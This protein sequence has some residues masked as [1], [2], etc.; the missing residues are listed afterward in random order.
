MTLNLKHSTTGVLKTSPTGFSW[1]TLFFGAFV[2]L[3]RGD[4]KWFVI[5]I[6]TSFFTCGLAWLVIPFIYNKR[7]IKD[8]LE[9]GYVAADEQTQYYLIG[10]GYISR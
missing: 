2:P 4:F 5:S 3:F 8:L 1:T 10:N 6:I 9:K 7:Y